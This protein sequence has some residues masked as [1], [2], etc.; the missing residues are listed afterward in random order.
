MKTTVLGLYKKI[1]Y[2]QT[3]YT[4]QGR[5]NAGKI[6][7]FEGGKNHANRCIGPVVLKSLY[8]LPARLFFIVHQPFI[9]IYTSDI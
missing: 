4:Q 2:Q 5:T 6:D 7:L 1:S 3:C 9:D 8:H